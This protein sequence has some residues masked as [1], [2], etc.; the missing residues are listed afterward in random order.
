MD[1]VTSFIEEKLKLKVNLNKVRSRP[2]ME[3][4]VSWI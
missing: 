4:K 1:S 3:E 2:S